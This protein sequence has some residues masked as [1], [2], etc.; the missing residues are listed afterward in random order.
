M[1]SR[2]RSVGRPSR[3]SLDALQDAALTLGLGSFTLAAVAKEVGVAEATVYN[4]VHSR[5]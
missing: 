1:I 3:T 2:R 5:C 4:Y